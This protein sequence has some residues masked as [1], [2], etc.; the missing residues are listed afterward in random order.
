MVHSTLT[1]ILQMMAGVVAATILSLGFAFLIFLGDAEARGRPLFSKGLDR[2]G[3]LVVYVSWFG[4]L[5][6]FGF[7]TS[8]LMVACAV[9]TVLCL[10]YVASY[11]KTASRRPPTPLAGS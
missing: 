3:A 4:L 1:V 9:T 11:Q 7:S 10:V 2:L 6:W 5:W 8:L